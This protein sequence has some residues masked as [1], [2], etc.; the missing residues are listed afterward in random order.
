MKCGIIGSGMAGLT[1]GAALAADGHEVILFEQ[2][3]VLGGVTAAFEQDGFRWDLGQLLVEGFGPD[4]PV[5]QIL[6][7]LQVLLRLARELLSQGGLFSSEWLKLKDQLGA[8]LVAESFEDVDVQEAGRI[9]AR[10]GPLA[11]ALVVDDPRTAAHAVA[12]SCH[13][14]ARL[15]D[16]GMEQREHPHIGQPDADRALQ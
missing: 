2:A 13:G 8:Q 10:L 4:E 3:E 15:G 16:D 5:G 1:A 14:R 12:G 7:E 11:Q 6:R 9:E